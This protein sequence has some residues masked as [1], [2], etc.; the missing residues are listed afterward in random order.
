MF[1]FFFTLVQYKV[2]VHILSFNSKRK[3]SRS[4][5]CLIW[6]CP[7]VSSAANT[8][9][10]FSECPANLEQKTGLCGAAFCATSYLPPDALR[11]TPPPSDDPVNVFENEDPRTPVPSATS[12]PPLKRPRRSPHSSTEP[13]TPHC[14]LTRSPNKSSPPRTPHSRAHNEQTC[15]RRAQKRQKSSSDVCNILPQHHKAALCVC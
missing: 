8:P 14:R 12:S 2:E 11:G 13:R 7:Q 6:F 15:Q 3:N 4:N 9:S 10:L 5:N 1:F